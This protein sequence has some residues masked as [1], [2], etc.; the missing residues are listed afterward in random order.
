MPRRKPAFGGLSR[1]DTEL[2]VAALFGFEHQHSEIEKKMAELRQQLGG[3]AAPVQ[4]KQAPKKRTMSASARRRI[5]AAQRKRWAAVKKNAKVGKTHRVLLGASG[6]GRST[7]LKRIIRESP[8]ASVIDP[9]G[10]LH[11]SRRPGKTKAKRTMSAE[12]RK[13]IGEATRKR[14]AA[15]KK[16]QGTK[17]TKSAPVKKRTMSAAAR[18]R[19]GEAT[20]KRWA[21]L[22]KKNGAAG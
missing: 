16:A 17:A 3:R 15:V 12:A 1:A 14:W 11:I 22:R 6:K 18:K 5:G 19:I 2:L 21:E 4:K 13:R 9:T 20:R 7:Y 8:G 10:A